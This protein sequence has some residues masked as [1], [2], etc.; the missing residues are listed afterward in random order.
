MRACVSACV[1]V[2]VF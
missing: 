2:C 1:S